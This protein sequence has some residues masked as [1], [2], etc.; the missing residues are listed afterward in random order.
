MRCAFAF[1]SLSS[2][3]NNGFTKPGRGWSSWYAAPDGSQVTDA[4]IR[5]NSVALVTS[6]LAAKGYTFSNVD[7]GWLAGRH[8]N[9]TIFEDMG[10]FPS[11]MKALG[12]YIKSIGLSYGLYTCRGTCQCSTDKYHGPGSHGYEVEDVNWIVAAGATWLKVDSCCGSQAHAVAFS[13]YARFRDALNATGVPVYFNL[14]GWSPW[15]A[16][17]DPALNYTGGA[18]L[19]N[20]WRISGDGASYGAITATM[21][22]LARVAV[23]GGGPSGT[24]DADNVLGPHGTVGV[25][26]EAQARAQFLLWALAPSQ[27][28][29]GEDM[30]KASAEYIETVGNEEMLAINY[31]TPF[32]GPARRVAGGDLT[33]PCASA[34]SQAVAGVAALPCNASD[35]A[36][37]WALD[38]AGGLSV[39]APAGA[40][41]SLT[42]C[43]N[44]DGAPLALFPAGWAGVNACD[45]ASWR[46]DKYNG[47]L[48]GAFGKCLDEYEMTTPR[49]DLWTCV[50]GAANEAW[51]PAGSSFSRG[52]LINQD[53][54]LCL[55]AVPLPPP[56]VCGNVWAR[57][58]SDG[59]FA[60]VFVWN[61]EE[62]GAVLCDAACFTA[63]NMT[64]AKYRVRDLLTHAD[65]GEISAPLSWSANLSAGG[66]GAAYKFTP[67]SSVFSPSDVCCAK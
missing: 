42:S 26:T 46:F 37:Q 1:L 30:T 31:D 6:G 3:I 16:F 22:I 51:A 67:F 57:P 33:Y 4:F 65:L 18:S 58:L 14:C 61:G 32:M 40:L 27:L 59:S 21:N 13:D 38:G 17:P 19:G 45:G 8:P 52:L 2:A 53:S 62:D 23:F 64:A 29:L 43:S 20:S 39:A 66:S 48:L 54:K 10:K 50:P 63:A 11:G 28:I 15:Y 9:G 56:A 55:A 47:S 7:E 35:P 60:Q 25:I 5:S 49:V 12:D 34:P 44:E 36:Q 24:N 41:L